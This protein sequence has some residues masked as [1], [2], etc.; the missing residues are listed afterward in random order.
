MHLSPEWDNE[1]HVSVHL[2]QE[3]LLKAGI[4]KKIG[5]TT[6]WH[7]EFRIKM[8]RIDGEGFTEKRVDF[9]IEDRNRYVS[10]LIE[11]KSAK[12]RIN[13]NAR[14]QLYD[15]YLYRSNI[16]YG[17]LI[18]PFSIEVY[19]YG[20]SNPKAIFEIESPTHIEPVAQCQY[21]KPLKF[22]PARY[23]KPMTL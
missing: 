14:F 21:D 9:L 8:P 2:V 1:A 4:P 16:K 20:Q 17:I 3:M 6:C 22:R 10:F 11:I 15:K 7:P 23:P 18:D 5:L 12:Q 13:D 19:E